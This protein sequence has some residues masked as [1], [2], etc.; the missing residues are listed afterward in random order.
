MARAKQRSVQSAMWIPLLLGFFACSAAARAQDIVFVA[1]TSVQ[2][3]AI[4][5]SDLHAIFSGEKNHFPDRSHAVPVILKGGPV[6]EVFL[7]NYCDESPSEFRAQWR[8]AIFTGQGS[9]PPSFDS[10]A[11]LIQY[12]S[13]TAGA[14]GYV[15]HLSPHEGVKVITALK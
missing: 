15:S 10:E 7:K 8:R 9:M 12:V 14:I 13:V 3:S 1:N 2:F 11:A 4:K 6:H 5:T